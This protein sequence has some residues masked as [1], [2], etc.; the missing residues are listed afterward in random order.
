M[1]D[2]NQNPDSDSV[3]APAW[4]SSQLHLRTWLDDIAAWLPAQHANYSPLIEYGYVLTSQGS[5]AAY[6]LDHALHCRSRLLVAHT[7]DSPSPRN[8]VF[9]ALGPTAPPNLQATTRQTRSQAQA[10]ASTAGSAAPATAASVSA[11][12][13]RTPD[14]AKRYIVAPE[15]VDASDRKMMTSILQTITCPAARRSY[16]ISANR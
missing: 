10:A 2:N 6:N 8:P 5:V 13:A 3:P 7:F 12:P 14:E 9:A 1:Q 16:A 11:L 4:D 15:L